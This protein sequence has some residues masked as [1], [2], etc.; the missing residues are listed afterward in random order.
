MNKIGIVTIGYNRKESIKRLI[1]SLLVATYTQDV[2][3]IISIDKSDNNQVVDYANSVEWNYGKK[4]VKTFEEN[5]GLKKHV[6]TCGNYLNE[7]NYDAIIVLEDDIVVAPGFFNYALQTIEYYKNNKNI[8]GISLYTHTWNFLAGRPFI[9][10]KS[11]SDVYFMQYAQSWGQI[12]MKNQW[13]DFYKWY[14]EKMFENFDLN[15]IPSN[16]LEWDEKSWLKYHIQYCIDKNKY[17]VY[18]YLSLTTNFSDAGTHNSF[19]NTGMQVPLDMSIDK[20]YV[21]SDLDNKSIMYDSFFE[22]VNLYKFLN[23]D[24]NEVEIDLFGTKKIYNKRYLFS[25]KQ[26]NYKIVKT[27]GLE[28]KP[29][30]LN[31]C[32]NIKGNELFLYDTN[33]II[34][35]KKNKK[36][37]IKHFSYDIRG[38]LI[39]RKK[40][41][42][43]AVNNIWRR[44]K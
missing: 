13:N 37:W 41:L 11:E 2:D 22:N 35:N 30:E 19:N 16:V 29:W 39:S 24:I 4:I 26:L 15:K 31:V 8:A 7:F 17:F 1:S 5:L 27:Y 9:P 25:T 32:Y 6:L 20:I 34:Q 38:D 40:V 14:E 36:N 12:W 28:L 23:L 18:P 33:E 21:L 43:Y 3:L 10:I 42:F 44:R